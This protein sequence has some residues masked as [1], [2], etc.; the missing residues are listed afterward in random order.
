M[1]TISFISISTPSIVYPYIEF[2]NLCGRS[3]F[4]LSMDPPE[5]FVLVQY[6]PIYIFRI[7]ITIN[8]K[9]YVQINSLKSKIMRWISSL[10]KIDLQ[11]IY[12][13]ISKCF[14]SWPARN[15]EKRFNFR[16]VGEATKFW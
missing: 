12:H 11:V 9:D 8:A 16:S 10:R 15:Q 1:R 5:N 4:F 13:R 2:F 14:S 6:M 7:S 3:W